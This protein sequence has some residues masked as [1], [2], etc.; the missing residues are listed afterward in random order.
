M[1]H[2]RRFANLSGMITLR[3]IVEPMTIPCPSCGAALLV[4][5]E[6]EVKAAGGG[7]WIKDGDTIQGFPWMLTPEQLGKNGY[8]CVLETGQRPC[9]GKDYFIFRCVMVNTE[10]DDD[11]AQTYFY[12]NR[13]RGP[14]T[15]FTATRGKREWLVERHESPLGPV[16]NHIFGPFKLDAASSVKGPDGVSGRHTAST[17]G[18]PWD[19]SRRALIELWS[20]LRALSATAT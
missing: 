19:F 12:M 1:R 15:Y 20:D 2:N 14:A 4:V 9:C 17:P 8:D 16:L 18:D 10:A 11:F 3:R 5:G 6:H 7:P 13:D